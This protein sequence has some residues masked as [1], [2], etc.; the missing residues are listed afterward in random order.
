LIPDVFL[1]LFRCRGLL[2]TR[3][4]RWQWHAL[5]CNKLR[6]FAVVACCFIDV[7]DSDVRVK[8]CFSSWTAALSFVKFFR[9]HVSWQQQKT[10]W[11]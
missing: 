2:F 9:E 11:I 3:G 10:Y 4:R 8:Y 6:S 1:I 5:R 7:R